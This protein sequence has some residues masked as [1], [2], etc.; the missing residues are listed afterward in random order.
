[1]V[2]PRLSN[3]VEAMVFSEMAIMV[4]KHRLMLSLILCMGVASLILFVPGSVKAGNAADE[5]VAARH[6]YSEKIAVKYNYRFGKEFPFFPSNATT[7]TG[8]FIDPKA[9]STRE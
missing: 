8:E 6:E 3:G 5:A 9:F 2:D 1:A 4:R 7:D